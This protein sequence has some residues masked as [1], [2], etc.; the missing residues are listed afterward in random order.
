MK[1]IWVNPLF[2]LNGIFKPAESK[3]KTLDEQN[4]YTIDV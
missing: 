3:W 4:G 2:A 1:D